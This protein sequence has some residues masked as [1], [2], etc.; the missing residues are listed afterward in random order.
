MTPQRWTPEYIQEQLNKPT[1]MKKKFSDVLLEHKDQLMILNDFQTIQTLDTIEQ[2]RI[3]DLILLYQ[4]IQKKDFIEEMKPVIDMCVQKK[5]FREL[6]IMVWQQLQWLY[7]QNKQYAEN[8]KD[9]K[10]GMQNE[11]SVQRYTKSLKMLAEEIKI[12]EQKKEPV[13]AYEIPTP[14]YALVPNIAIHM[15]AARLPIENILEFLKTH[16]GDAQIH[17]N[18]QAWQSIKTEL[19]NNKK[20]SD[21]QVDSLKKKL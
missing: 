17:H 11:K 7:S 21:E 18:Q 15:Q 3:T 9:E 12:L 14:W 5:D 20:K 16:N 13:T 10:T 1:A 8:S 19:E 4:D 6:A 2:F